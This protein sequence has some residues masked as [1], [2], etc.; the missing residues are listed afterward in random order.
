M[1]IKLKYILS[2]VFLLIAI[3]V[4]FLVWKYYRE[5]EQKFHM[6][7]ALKLYT[8]QRA[9]PEEKNIN[10]YRDDPYVIH[11]RKV[12]D[13]YLKGQPKLTEEYKN[14]VIFGEEFNRIPT[15]RRKSFDEYCKSRFVVCW[16]GE[17]LMGGRMIDLIFQDKPDKLFYAWVYKTTYAYELRYF[18]E[19]TKIKTKVVKQLVKENSPG[20]FDKEHSL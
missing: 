2:S 7:F 10:I 5:K 16:I 12:L 8:I 6:F 4:M 19:Q 13:G 14:A 18:Y 17:N 3:V 15:S 1:K 9:L 20:I 11:I